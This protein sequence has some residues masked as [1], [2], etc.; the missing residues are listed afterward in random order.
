[1][2]RGFK[3]ALDLSMQLSLMAYVVQTLV[4]MQARAGLVHGDISPRN[5]MLRKLGTAWG[6]KLF[7]LGSS[8]S[9]D[10]GMCKT[11]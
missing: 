8:Q 7:D 10:P 3:L 2:Q 4:F 6:L 1:M 11:A 5:I 9:F